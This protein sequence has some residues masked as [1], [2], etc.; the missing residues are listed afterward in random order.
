MVKV[1]VEYKITVGGLAEYRAFM[2]DLTAAYPDLE[3]LEGADQ[4]GL[5][6][7]SWTFAGLAEANHWIAQ[8]RDGSSLDWKPLEQ[9]VDGGKAKIHMWPFIQMNR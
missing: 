2:K 5:F 7:E 4:P 3:W 1:L 6:V 9:W 8:R